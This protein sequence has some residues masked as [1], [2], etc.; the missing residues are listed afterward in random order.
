M[1]ACAVICRKA[2]VALPD[3]NFLSPWCQSLSSRAQNRHFCALLPS[4][5]PVFGHFEHKIEVF[6]LF[7]P[8]EPPFSGISSTKSR[9]LCAFGLRNPH[10]RHFRAQNRH[11]CALWW[12]HGSGHGWGDGREQQERRPGQFGLLTFCHKGALFGLWHSI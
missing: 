12:G 8:S 3:A 9:F 1:K 7:W 11:F 5:T 10:F 6:V 4:G 2:T